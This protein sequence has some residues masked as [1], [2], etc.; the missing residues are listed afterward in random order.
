MA[1]QVVT[2]TYT[3]SYGTSLECKTT[4]IRLGSLPRSSETSDGGPEAGSGIKSTNPHLQRTHRA[5]NPRTL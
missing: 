4:S 5:S 3:A 2:R 1:K